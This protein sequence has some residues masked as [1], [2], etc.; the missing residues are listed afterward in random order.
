MHSNKY[1]FSTS[2]V[3]DSICLIKGASHRFATSPFTS[4]ALISRGNGLPHRLFDVVRVIC[5]AV[6]FCHCLSGFLL[7]APIL[8]CSISLHPLQQIIKIL[9][10]ILLVEILP[11]VLFADFVDSYYPIFIHARMTLHQHLFVYQM[12]QRYESELWVVPVLAR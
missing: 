6:L 8:A 2:S 4:L 3:F 10:E 9:V 1:N 12:C 5:S 7:V 11:I